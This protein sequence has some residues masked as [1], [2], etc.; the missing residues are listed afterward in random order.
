MMGSRSPLTAAGTAADY[1]PGCTAFPVRLRLRR[2][3]D[4]WII[5][6]RFHGV[7][8]TARSSSPAIAA[9]CRRGGNRLMDPDA[10]GPA[11][12]D[13]MAQPVNTA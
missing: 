4:G 9:S 3:D 8:I 13:K 5:A 1:P 7:K 12:E 6:A 2:T 10:A 11:A